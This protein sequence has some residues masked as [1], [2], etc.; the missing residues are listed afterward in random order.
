MAILVFVKKKLTLLFVQ[1]QEMIE[2][3]EDDSKGS[4][5]RR[6]IFKKQVS[7]I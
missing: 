3:L 4:A 1:L 2:S 6:E 5:N 7:Q